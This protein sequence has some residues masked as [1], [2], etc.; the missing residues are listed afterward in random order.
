MMKTA[1]LHHLHELP[2]GDPAG[3]GDLLFLQAEGRQRHIPPEPPKIAQRVAAAQTAEPF[4]FGRGGFDPQLL[5][6]LARGGRQ[7]VLPRQ[8]G[9]SGYRPGIRHQF[10]MRGAFL[11]EQAALGILHPDV[12]HQMILPWPELVPPYQCLSQRTAVAVQQIPF[13]HSQAA[14]LPRRVPSHR[15]ETTYS[16]C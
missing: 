16:L 3:V 12:D 15:P 5:R 9:A 8:G 10:E 6:Q 2:A 7:A 1:A 14:S 4:E 13:F 11:D